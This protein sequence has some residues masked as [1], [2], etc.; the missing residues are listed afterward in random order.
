[1][2]RFSQVLAPAAYFLILA[3]AFAVDAFDV[4]GQTAGVTYHPN[5]VRHA[6]TG[7]RR[8]RIRNHA[9]NTATNA[10]QNVC[11][12]HRELMATKRNVHAT[13]IGK[14]RKEVQNALEMGVWT[15]SIDDTKVD[16]HF[17][18]HRTTSIDD[19]KVDLHELFV[20]VMRQGGVFKE[21]G[22]ARSK[23]KLG[24]H[25]FKPK[26]KVHRFKP[27]VEV[28]RLKSKLFKPK[29]HRFTLKSKVK[30][31]TTGV[32]YHPELMATKSN[33]HATTIEKL[34]KEVQ[35]ALE[36]GVWLLRK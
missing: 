14:L 30:G 10:V 6:N 27:K 12:F 28:H 19:T 9:Y 29:V 8:H 18:F 32:T 35:N 3:L 2:A 1:M 34:R 13:T 21:A 4:K 23:L 33:V 25:L 7:V 17:L 16:L 26:H 22:D 36:M 15:T 31:Q 5:V 11:V 24:V 20:E